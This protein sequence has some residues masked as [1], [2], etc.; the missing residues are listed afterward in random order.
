MSTPKDHHYVPQFYLRRFCRDGKLWV[1]DKKNKKYWSQYPKEVAKKTHYYSIETGEGTPDASVEEIF[2]LID[3][4]SAEVFKKIDDEV[5]INNIDKSTLATFIAYQIVRVP[6]HRDMHS[7]FIE[8]LGLALSKVMF[9]TNER[10][11]QVMLNTGT[12]EEDIDEKLVNRL[13]E[14]TNKDGYVLEANKNFGIKHMLDMGGSICEHIHSL[15]WMIFRANKKAAFITSD[16][17]FTIIEPE[18]F[19]LTVL[20][21]PGIHTPGAKKVFPMSTSHCLVMGDRGSKVLYVPSPMKLIRYLNCRT[22][23]NATRFVM[24]RDCELL[25]RVAK[26]AD[27]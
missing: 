12:K 9:S 25:K 18:G 8:R 11:R 2:T 17:P 20:R 22:A 14:M 24:A 16:N 26:A 15:T 1:Y 23:I 4:K 13:V 7:S 3:G 21:S 5:S 27:I 19:D 10:V 6:A